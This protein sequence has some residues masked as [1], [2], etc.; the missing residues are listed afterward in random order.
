MDTN[1]EESIVKGTNGHPIPELTSENKFFAIAT[2]SGEFLS[3][4]TYVSKDDASS[5][6][7]QALGLEKDSDTGYETVP[8]WVTIRDAR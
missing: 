6:L 4:K 5:F 1:L 3:T 8:V 7:Q 2:P